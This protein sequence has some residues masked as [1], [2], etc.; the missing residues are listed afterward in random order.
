MDDGQLI[1]DPIDFNVW[2][3]M[4]S[5]IYDVATVLNVKEYRHRIINVVDQIITNLTSVL[6]KS[7]LRKIMYKKQGQ[8]I[9]E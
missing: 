4:N 9:R 5:R 3:H 6:V 7:E 1:V 8:P 2:R